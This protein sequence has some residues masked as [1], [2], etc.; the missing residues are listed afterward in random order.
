MMK[1]VEGRCWLDS[2]VEWRAGEG[3]KGR[4]RGRG[5]EERDGHF[6]GL[7]L[8]GEE[9]KG[10]GEE[11]ERRGRGEERKGRGVKQGWKRWRD[12]WLDAQNSIKVV[13]CPCP[14]PYP[15]LALVP[16]LVP[17]LVL[18]LVPALVPVLVPVLLYILVSAASLLHQSSTDP[19]VCLEKVI[20][21]DER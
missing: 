7:I 2:G 15:F 5:G 8:A 11:R 17:V 4:G 6:V 19:K 14:C 16:V 12:I 20:I 3:R 21:E 9:R 13:S 10:R 18:V 1:C